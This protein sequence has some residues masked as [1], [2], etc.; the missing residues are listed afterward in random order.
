MKMKEFKPPVEGACPRRPLDPPMYQTVV[1]FYLNQ[2]PCII[3]GIVPDHHLDV[4]IH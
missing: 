1:L 3:I 2:V 4:E